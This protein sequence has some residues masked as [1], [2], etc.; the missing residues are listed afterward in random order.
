MPVSGRI[1]SPRLKGV[2]AT[3]LV[4]WIEQPSFTITRR[5][6]EKIFEKGRFR[7]IARDCRSV[8]CFPLGVREEKRIDALRLITDLDIGSVSERNVRT[9]IGILVAPSSNK[10]DDSHGLRRTMRCE[11]S[12][13]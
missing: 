8:I 12:R 11:V 2:L 1:N 6:D 9:V 4:A 13:R 7:S 5:S 3:R 10:S